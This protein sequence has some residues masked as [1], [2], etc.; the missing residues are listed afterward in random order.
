MKR[1]HVL[2][3]AFPVW[4]PIY[5]QWTIK[6][7]IIKLP[8][9][10]IEYLLQDGVVL[11]VS[12]ADQEVI[13]NLRAENVAENDNS[14]GDA[15]D[16]WSD[17]EEDEILAPTFP[18]LERDIMKRIR[19]LGGEVFPKLNW[20]APRD[21]CW[22]SPNGTLKCSS[23]QDICLLLKSSDF[24]AHDLMNAFEYCEDSTDSHAT[25]QFELILRKWVEISPAAEFRCFVKKNKLVAISQRDHTNFYEHNLKNKDKIHEDITR[26]FK[27]KI[28]SKFI[29]STFIFDIYRYG[30]GQVKLIDINPFSQVTD[31]LLFSWHE[32]S[33]GS[34]LGAENGGDVE[35][36][37]RV[38]TCDRNLQPSPYLSYRMPKDVGDI[39]S[40]EDINKLVEFFNEKK[41]TR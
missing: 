26:F 37:L 15:Y 40:G 27:T 39:A 34:L 23:F 5:K 24:I 4:Y 21:A 13:T 16:E 30:E 14:D 6:S 36:E 38:V 12:A 10:F 20:S 2:N 9:E 11:P 8:P 1:Q 33:D 22:I 28:S 19:E 35:G 32:I 17:C 7:K 18:D 25:D 41:L 29:E 3:C 31:T